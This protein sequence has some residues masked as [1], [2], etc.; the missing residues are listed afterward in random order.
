[1]SSPFQS[2]SGG[3][4]SGTNFSVIAGSDLDPEVIAENKRLKEVAWRKQIQEEFARRAAAQNRYGQS[5][6]QGGEGAGGGFGSIGVSPSAVGVA[7]GVTGGDVVGGMISG[8]GTALGVP[9]S[10]TIGANVSGGINAA[11]AVANA[12]SIGGVGG[13]S[14]GSGGNAGG[15]GVG[16]ADS[17]R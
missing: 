6:W 14:G 10:S 7:P 17:P 11:N 12:A 16:G 5:T 8:I 1:M 2:G 9:G 15:T 13:G 4:N 3:F